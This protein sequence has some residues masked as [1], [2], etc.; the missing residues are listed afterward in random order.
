MMELDLLENVIV[1]ETVCGAINL[2]FIGVQ[3]LQNVA[4]LA[5]ELDIELPEYDLDSLYNDDYDELIN[6]HKE[7]MTTLNEAHYELRGDILKKIEEMEEERRDLKWEKGFE[8]ALNHPGKGLTG[9]E[10]SNSIWHDD[11][12]MIRCIQWNAS[13]IVKD[14]A[15]L[16]PVVDKKMVKHI[17]KEYC[18]TTINIDNLRMDYIREAI[19]LAFLRS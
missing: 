19:N 10:L 17:Y 1:V 5:E 4:C 2:N 7:Y 9:I 15:C 16:F 3:D 12:I 13:K 6:I 18:S 8:Y 11:I 14:P